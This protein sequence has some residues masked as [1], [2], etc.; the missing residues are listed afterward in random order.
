MQLTKS[1]SGHFKDV[2]SKK[3]IVSGYL[4]SFNIKDSDGDI[5]A[6]GSFLKTIQEN[7]PQGTGRIKYCQDHDTRKVVGVFQLL[8]EDNFGLYYDAKTSRDTKG[9]DYLLMVEDGIITEHSIGYRVMQEKRIDDNTNM[10]TEYKLYEGSGLQFWGANQYTPITGI[11]SEA[12]MLITIELL[13]KAL[14]NA[15]YT[16]ETFKTVIIPKLEGLKTLIQPI[17][18]PI[19]SITLPTN[20]EMKQAIMGGFL[21]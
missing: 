19:T 2:D 15:N 12:D 6:E 21:I 1:I 8:K 9:V 11:K 13:E 3:G 16:D 14:K 4:N 20:E 7:G 5:S 18:K 10:I 17:T